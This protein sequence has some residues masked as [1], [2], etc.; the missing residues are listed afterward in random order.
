M[1][2]FNGVKRRTRFEYCVLYTK[3]R[4]I[5]VSLESKGGED[6]VVFREERRRQAWSLP[7]DAAFKYAVRLAAL[8]EAREKRSQRKV[9]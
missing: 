7:V 1:T 2:D 6:L 4:R 5:V 9:K 8:S 3:P